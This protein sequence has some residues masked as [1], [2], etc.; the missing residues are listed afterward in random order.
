[1]RC[2]TLNELPPPAPGKTSWP[3]DRAPFDYAQDR[4]DRPGA[5]ESPQLLKTVPN[6]SHLLYVSI[7]TLSWHTI[8]ICSSRKP[9]APCSSRC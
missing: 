6:G 8:N 7:V 3:F 1:M 4:Q 9:Y 2:P 5:E